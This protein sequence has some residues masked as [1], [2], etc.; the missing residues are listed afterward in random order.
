MASTRSRTKLRSL[1]AYERALVLPL[2][3]R[4]A[5]EVAVFLRIGLDYAF[6]RYTS[7]ELAA[8]AL[9]KARATPSS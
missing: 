6:R 8:E 7:D 5:A 3:K 9:I 2:R 1:T 4:M